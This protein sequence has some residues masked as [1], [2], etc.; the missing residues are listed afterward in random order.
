MTNLTNFSGF[1]NLTRTGL[2]VVGNG[3]AGWELGSSSSPIDT[4]ANSLNFAG[5]VLPTLGANG[6]AF[7]LGLNAAAGFTNTTLAIGKFNEGTLQTTDVL[8]ITA[9]LTAILAA[10][11]LVSGAVVVPIGALL[12]ISAVSIA[13]GPSPVKNQINEIGLALGAWLLDKVASG[14]IPGDPNIHVPNG[15]NGPNG[16]SKDVA[17]RITGSVN[18]ARDTRSPLVLDLDGDGIETLG[19]DS[20]VNFDHDK[21]GFAEATGWVAPDDGL[22]V[23][24]RNADGEINNGGELF[25]NSTGNATTGIFSNGFAALSTLDSNQDGVVNSLDTLF[26][27]LRVWRDLNADGFSQTSELFSLGA[28]NVA[29]INLAFAEQGSVDAN[30]DYVA[31]QTS[32]VDSFGNE[33]RQL[34]SYTRTDGSTR[35]VEDVWFNADASLTIDLSKVE[36]SLANQALP[37]VEGF[38]NVHNLRLAMQ[39]DGSG[40][41]KALV[42]QFASET[43][44]DVRRDLVVQI[45]Y[46]WAGVQN[47]DPN[48]RAATQFYGNVIG[49][50]RKLEALE[51]FVG[52]EYLGTWCWG[53]R[54]PNPHGVAAPILLRTFEELAV[55]VYGS[56]MLQTH[57]RP[58]FNLIELKIQNGQVVWDVAALV[59]L[60]TTE[61]AT[62]PISTREKIAEFSVIVA[63]LGVS[64]ATPIA[65]AIRTF[66]VTNPLSVGLGAVLSEFGTPTTVGSSS[67]DSILGSTA[68][69][70]MLGAGGDDWLYGNEGNDT[71]DGGTGNDYLAG[72]NGAD[73]YRFERGDGNDTILNSDVDGYGIN[74]DTIR[75]GVGIS[76]QEVIARRQGYD[77]YLSIAGTADGVVVQSYFDRDGNAPDGFVVERIEFENGVV[78]N[79]NQ[80][81][82]LV[83]SP[84]QGNDTIIG[85]EFSDDQLS[86]A[87]GDDKLSGLGGSDRLHGGLGNDNLEGDL[88]DDVY[89]YVLGDGTDLISDSGGIDRVE[90]GQGITRQNTVVR[91]D[92]RRQGFDLTFNDGGMLLLSG[93][94]D[95]VGDV[96]VEGLVES[97]GFA[98]G[99]V[100][101][102]DDLKQ[103]SVLGTENR[104]IIRGFKTNDSIYSYGGDDQIFGIAAA[105]MIF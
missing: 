6:T 2:D 9:N 77:L 84:T 76:D 40:Q 94:F 69:D 39:L 61:Y 60:W 95:G 81:R 24:D 17:L 102:L 65:D 80:V 26:S 12:V 83:L 36:V 38:G 96:V 31:A 85:Y 67:N 104:E 70:L 52:R 89:V 44:S 5:Q 93:F 75:F 33:H 74:A 7:G 68:G 59:E 42:N 98:N 13:A 101:T 56:L 49:D 46:H 71:L 78:W 58:L 34:G 10:A 22:L 55:Y 88:G 11:A 99:T 43:N 86:G 15:P 87:A 51:E 72:G 27:N 45:V 32:S 92:V 90:F 30:G 37:E 62:D 91:Y 20:G 97:I 73:T 100:W 82:A 105:V 50:A 1:G 19:L 63:T 53:A 54:D 21:N 16:R 64:T 35:V 4:F 66:G 57:S 29:G 18:K 25:G 41:L 3:Q 47:V 14:D 103:Q 79:V 8:Q 28:V 48:S 23:L